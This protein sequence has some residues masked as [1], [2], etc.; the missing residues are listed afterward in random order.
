MPTPRFTFALVL[1]LGA[2]SA[3]SAQDSGPLAALRARGANPG[4]PFARLGAVETGAG[5]D[6]SV[7]ARARQQLG[8]RYVY[9]AASPERGFD[10]SGLVKYILDSFGVELPHNAARIATLGT[11]VRADTGALRPG[12]LLMFGRGRSSRISHVGI[13]VGG[14]K[15][16]HAS[17]SQ[18]RV[19]ETAVPAR[20]SSLKLRTVRRVLADS[21]VH[22]VL[23]DSLSR[24]RSE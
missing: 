5:K 4:G 21:T 3:A 14:G 1:L 23:A 6:S 16:I 19:I 2:A 22:R 8:K 24:R 10:C 17:T 18:R 9:A 15:M 13:Y 7:I 11:A 12:D 20:T